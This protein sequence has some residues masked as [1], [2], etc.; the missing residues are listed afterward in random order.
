[1]S[2]KKPPIDPT[3][4]GVQEAV[5]ASP[6]HRALGVRVRHVGSDGLVADVTAT[7]SWC[8]TSDEPTV[9]GGVLATLLDMA[10][11]HS[12]VP[13][14]GRPGPTITLTVN[15]L[16]PVAPGP[17]TVVGR[18][19]RAGGS[20]CVLESEVWQGRVDPLSGDVEGTPAAVARGSFVS[21]RGEQSGE[22][23]DRGPGENSEV[24][25]SVDTD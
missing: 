14:T 18:V 23:V 21:R 17:L 7:E 20:V 2:E 16:A 3:P 8:N 6:V 5:D 25:Q 12:V 24:A 19:V 1:M 15:Y 11:A 10:A 9:H 4:A 22:A 13:V